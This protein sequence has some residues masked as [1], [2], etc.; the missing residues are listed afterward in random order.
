MSILDDIRKDKR[1]FI[2]CP[3]CDGEFKASK[4][5][6]FDATK[7]L[8]KEAESLLA[9]KR[10]AHEA[11]KEALAKRKRMIGK[12]EITAKAVNIGKIVEKIATVLPG[13]AARPADCRS[14]FEPID[15]IV[16]E[17]LSTSGRVESIHFAELKSGAAKLN[18][19]Q[20]QIRDAI[21]SGKVDFAVQDVEVK[22]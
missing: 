19:H 14:L 3:C 15:F 10:K 6:L 20:K 2:R 9:E 17:G 7:P 13:F 18:E 21:E 16:F 1:L 5:L 8:P 11:D 22:R 4:A 12:A